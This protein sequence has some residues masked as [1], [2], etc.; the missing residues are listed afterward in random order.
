LLLEKAQFL[1]SYS[2]SRIDYTV[3]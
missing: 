2:A 1:M 3:I